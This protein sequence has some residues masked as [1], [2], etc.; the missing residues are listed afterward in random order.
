MSP[1][2]TWED[3]SNLGWPKQEVYNTLN[4]QRGNTMEGLGDLAVNDGICETYG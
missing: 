3:L 4:A 2:T 1:K